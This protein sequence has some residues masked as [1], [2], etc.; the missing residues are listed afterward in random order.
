VTLVV[1]VA[2]K[3]GQRRTRLYRSKFHLELTLV[4]VYV[5]VEKVKLAPKADPL[6]I[7]M[8]K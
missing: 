5:L 2:A 3:V 7:Y 6:V 1:R 8:S 4:I